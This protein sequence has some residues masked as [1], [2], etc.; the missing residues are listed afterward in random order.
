MTLFKHG[1]LVR[2]PTL[3]KGADKLHIYVDGYLLAFGMLF[4]PDGRLKDCPSEIPALV[5]VN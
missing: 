2:A 5:L 4:T 3:A 1:D